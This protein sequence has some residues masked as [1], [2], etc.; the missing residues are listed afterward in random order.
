MKAKKT[1]TISMTLAWMVLYVFI[2][3]TTEEAWRAKYI[4]N[5]HFFITVF[6][7][8][9]SC[10][11]FT[12]LL[13]IF[14]CVEC[15]YKMWCC[16]LLVISSMFPLGW[17]VTCTLVHHNTFTNS[18]SYS[19]MYTCIKTQEMLFLHDLYLFIA[20]IKYRSEIARIRLSSYLS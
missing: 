8:F 5:F 11:V 6:R 14:K 10:C 4:S 15:V 1:W 19:Y 9:P 2:W 13:N 7:Y 12:V 18:L 3:Q 16:V 17:W 20:W